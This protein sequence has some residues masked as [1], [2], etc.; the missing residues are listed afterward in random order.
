[1]ARRRRAAATPPPSQAVV[2]AVA[3]QCATAE[4][5]KYLISRTD[6]LL[7]VAR[8]L[9]G[10]MLARC[11]C[12]CRAW[13]D[14]LRAASQLWRDALAAD[15][16]DVHGGH[17]ASRHLLRRLEARFGERLTS[18]LY[19][20]RGVRLPP[21]SRFLAYATRVLNEVLAPDFVPPSDCDGGDDD[22]RRQPRSAP[23]FATLE[24]RVADPVSQR[25]LRRSRDYDARS[26]AES[27]GHCVKV[28]E[29][30]A[31]RGPRAY[32]QLCQSYGRL[33]WM[34]PVHFREQPLVART[35]PKR[36][37][38]PSRFSPYEMGNVSDPDLLRLAPP[39][40]G[41]DGPY[42]M[43]LQLAARLLRGCC[44][45]CNCAT[46]ARHPVLRVPICADGACGSAFRVVPAAHVAASAKLPGG[47]AA[48]VRA[49]AA[50]G[51][52]VGA[53]APSSARRRNRHRKAKIQPA[54]L[55]TTAAEL[56]AQA[57]R[58]Q[59]LLEQ[60]MAKRWQSQSS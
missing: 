50:S 14:Q 16:W 47:A 33:Q 43:Y 19:S 20:Y 53:V 22:W 58:Q 60:Q 4:R 39:G 12:V 29:R 27:A 13:R 59:R 41:A 32:H 30:P 1:M 49:A 15:F 54:V 11:V 51:A 8:G 36:W 9:P 46:D 5:V 38:A 3:E 45:V 48:V 23:W 6:L 52:P 34:R 24:Q 21:N 25:E 31:A 44:R 57:Q 37:R 42:R 18:C 55:A 28:R 35:V 2:A 10:W 26:A 40:N 7:V 56:V 17:A